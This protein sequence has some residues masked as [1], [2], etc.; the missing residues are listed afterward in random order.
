M[1]GFRCFMK[2]FTKNEVLGRVPVPLVDVIYSSV[3]DFRV[4]TKMQPNRIKYSLLS[5]LLIPLTLVTGPP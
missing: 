2:W 4:S 1:S 5:Y 3:Q